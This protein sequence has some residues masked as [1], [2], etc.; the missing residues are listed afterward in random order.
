MPN[1]V[2]SFVQLYLYPVCEQRIQYEK[3]RNTINIYMSSSFY[4]QELTV[5][6]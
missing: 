2:G 1:I 6:W 5:N 4:I 3:I